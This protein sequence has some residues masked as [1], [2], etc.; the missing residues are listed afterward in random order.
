[1]HELVAQ[2]MD[3]RLLDLLTRWRAAGPAPVIAE[4]A[5]TFSGH[6]EH[7]LV[8]DAE[9]GSNRYS[10]YGAAFTRHFGSDLTG[11]V[12]DVLPAHILPAE[13]RGMLEFEYTFARQV[14]LPLWRSYTAQFGDRTETWQ[15]L[16]L[17]VGE[18]RL[19]VGAYP[20]ELPE[21]ADSASALLRLMIDRVPVVLDGDGGIRDLALSLKSFCDTQQHVA[22][23][24]V[25]AT[26]DPLTG[27]AN[28][29][30]FHHLASLELDHARRMGRSFSLLALDIDHF[31]AINDRWGHAAGDEALKAF[32]AACRVA[33][34]EY[35]I[36]GRVGGEE[37]AVALPNTGLDGARVIGERLRRQVEE[38]VVRP[39]K[40]EMFDLTVS[41]GITAEPTLPSG[42]LL[43]IPGLL[44]QADAA[45]YRAKAMGRN[46]VVV[47]EGLT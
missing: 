10:H 20:V 14:S 35:D 8:I 7:L 11:C 47:A 15:R 31:K 5:R 42:A 34:R 19:A 33:L 16:V 4:P 18:G 39:A 32:V 37:F 12:I 13:R 28:L 9:G 29:R 41:V 27:V 44:A 22:E 24:E 45:L 36:L 40:G 43:D 17:P 6:A 2:V 26:R 1:M 38:M 21:T 23:L 3:A 25:L 30:H 46:R